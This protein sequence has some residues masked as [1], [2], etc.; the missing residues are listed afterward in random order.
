MNFILRLKNKATLAALI[1][2]VIAFVYQ[3]LGIF[4]VVPAISQ[5]TITQL[6]G[7]VVNILVA[8]GVVVDPTTAGVKD[9]A[10]AMTYDEPKK[11]EENTKEGEE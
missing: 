1:A 3:M 8:L 4:G 9:S 7:I 11:A 5:D 2:A 6:L 10:Q